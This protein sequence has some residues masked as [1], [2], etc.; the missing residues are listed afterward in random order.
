MRS[1]KK[2]SILW[3]W[4]L[5]MF[6]VARGERS[7]A[8]DG[9]RATGYCTYTS[10]DGA[11]NPVYK[12]IMLFDVKVVDT[13]WY[14]RT[15]PVIE[16]KG[17]IGFYEA[18]HG[19]NGYVLSVSALESAYKSSESPF[20]SLRSQLKE[21]KN[22]DVFFS[23]T[24][25]R[26]PEAFPIPYWHPLDSSVKPKP[27][28]SSNSSQVDN[29][30]VANIF[31]GKCPPTDPSY[32]SFLWFAFTPPTEQID[33]TNRMLLQIWDDGNPTRNRFRRA[34]WSQFPE[35]PNLVST[36]EFVWAGKEP[37]ADGTMADINTSDVSKP[38]EIAAR[39]EVD[40]VTNLSGL[41][42][43][44]NFKLTR[45]G[46]ERLDNKGPG[47]VSTLFATVIKV[48]RVSSSVRL[49]ATFP[50]KTFVSDYRLSAGKLGGSPLRYIHDSP[51]LPS[52]DQLKQSGLYR[53]ASRV[54]EASAPKPFLRWI[55]L[56]GFMIPSVV[57]FMF[58]RRSA[59]P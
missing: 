19:T 16:G 34:R 13:E 42:V 21:S 15:E 22:D 17:G 30:A 3:H 20:G 9:Y 45:F 48:G 32:G 52:V 31:L 26:L 23:N 40:G 57:L 35:F 25:F 29:V 24:T 4:I 46:T 38:L 2:T 7:P 50:G 56:I 49:E 43:P 12:N 1:L 51:Q 37:R 28:K 5:A 39:F 36:A 47:I 27:P 53:R 10:F 6:L 18:S 54:V 44:L 11:R 58:W 59:R 14:I 33:G 41:V 55:L 8:A